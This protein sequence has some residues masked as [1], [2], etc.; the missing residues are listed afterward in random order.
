[1]HMDLSANARLSR[2]EWAFLGM[3]V[4]LLVLFGVLVVYR[5]A[6]SERRMG[7]VN[8][9]LRAAWAARMGGE[10]LYSIQSENRLNYHYPPLFA[11]LLSPLADPPPGAAPCFVPPFAVSVLIWFCINV[12]MLAW[13]VHLLASLV[14]SAAAQPPVRFGRRWWLLRLLPVGICLVDVGCTLNHGQV[15]IL[16]LLCFA[17][18]IRAYLLRQTFHSGLWLGAAACVK[19]FP[20]FLILVPLWRRDLGCL[21]GFGVAL[22]VGLLALPVAVYGPTR[23]LSLYVELEHVLIGPA[24][25]WGEDQ[26]RHAQLFSTEG[27]SSQSLAAAYTHLLDSLSPATYT[28][29]P[30]LARLLHWCT[31]LLVV[32]GLFAMWRKNALL[33]SA[34]AR[35]TQSL[36]FFGGMC[37]LM[38]L[39]CPVAHKH[40]LMLAL[41]LVLAMCGLILDPQTSH[42]RH[43]LVPLGIFL[44]ASICSSL[45]GLEMLKEYCV[46]LY[47]SLFLLG[48]ALWT[49]TSWSIEPCRAS[50]GGVAPVGLG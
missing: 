16:L 25:G 3:L 21:A 35:V 22:F 43:L 9:L 45:P 50:L 33:P 18:G 14:E 2:W 8:M 34:S 41:P 30:M 29:P 23:T 24:L 42:M 44:L 26:T 40:Y 49:G 7:D 37:L 36:L 32:L 15:T 19:I 13:A 17:V 31:G 4:P 6:L 28:T 47:A 38:V 27:P 48:T 10:G 39:L 1:M 11:F 12:G 20:A 46:P 5:S